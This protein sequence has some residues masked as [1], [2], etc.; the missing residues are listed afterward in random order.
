MTSPDELEYVVL[1]GHRR[2]FRRAGSGPALLLL[3]GFGCDSSTWRAII[4]SLAEHFTVIAPDLLGHGA[5]GKPNADYSL[6]GYANGMRDLLTVLGI[7]TATVVG[8][9]FGGGGAMQFAYQFPERTERTMLISTGGLGPAVTPFVR[10]LTSRSRHGRQV[11]AHERAT[12]GDGDQV[13]LDQVGLGS[14]PV[15]PAP[16]LGS[17]LGAVPDTVRDSGVE[18]AG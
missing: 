18:V 16:A 1:H 17:E 12:A 11:A 2:A 3:H 6:G 14:A 9:S 7:D 15:E 10:F 4:E 13:G 5:S 8:H